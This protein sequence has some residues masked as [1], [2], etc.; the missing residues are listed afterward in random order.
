MTTGEQKFF[1]NKGACWPGIPSLF[2]T[3]VCDIEAR[4]NAGSSGIGS[5][6]GA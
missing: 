6:S 1:E 4:K 2:T 5:L 3:K